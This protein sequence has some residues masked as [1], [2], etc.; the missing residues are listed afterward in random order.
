MLMDMTV[1]RNLFAGSCEG[2]TGCVALVC[3]KK[4]S[5]FQDLKPF[6]LLVFH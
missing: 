5:H 3:I 2:F 4:Y 6:K 1:D